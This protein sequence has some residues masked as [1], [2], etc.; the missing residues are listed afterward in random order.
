MAEKEFKFIKKSK[1]DTRASVTRSALINAEL[2]ISA[3][4]GAR[5]SRIF[6]DTGKILSFYLSN[7]LFFADYHPIFSCLK[8]RKGFCRVKVEKWH[9]FIDTLD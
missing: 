7:I 9:F 1:K 6:P 8:I 4:M 2:K 5:L 3:V